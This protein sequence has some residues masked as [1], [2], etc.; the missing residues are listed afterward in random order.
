[1]KRDAIQKWMGWI[2][3][4]VL[5]VQFYFVKEMFAAELMFAIGFVALTVGFA[6]FYVLS[7]V[8]GQLVRAMELLG[9]HTAGGAQ[10][11]MQFFDTISRKPF[12]HPHSQS[13]R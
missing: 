4:V 12:R 2:V 13:V 1:M 7:A 6:I 11:A 10:S 3:A 5:A 9:R 8:G